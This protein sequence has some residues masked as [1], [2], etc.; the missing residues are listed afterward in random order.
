MLISSYMV[1]KILFFDVKTLWY[2]YQMR[3][4]NLSVIRI[5]RY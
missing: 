1:L 4:G 2:C 5:L 3:L